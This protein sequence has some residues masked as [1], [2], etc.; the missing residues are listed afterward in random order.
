MTIQIETPADEKALAEFVRFHD[1]VYEYRAVRWSASQHFQL[2]ILMGA[3]PHGAGREIK[4]FVAREGGAIVAR[5]AAIIDQHYIKHW[6][7]QLGHIVMFE[8]MP[9]TSDAVKMMLE[10]ACIWMRSRAGW[11]PRVRAPA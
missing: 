10:E 8:A 7:E 3:P 2:H 11:K 6:N 5:A 1:R 9:N 4:S